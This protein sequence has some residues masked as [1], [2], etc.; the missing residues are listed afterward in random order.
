MIYFIYSLFILSIF[1]KITCTLGVLL[2][3]ICHSALSVY[4]SVFYLCEGEVW[5][6]VLGASPATHWGT[7]IN[8]V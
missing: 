8:S 6:W 5:L 7:F 4:I 1:L 2:I 3:L